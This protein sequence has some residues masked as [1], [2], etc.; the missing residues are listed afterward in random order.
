MYEDS[1]HVSVA[2]KP[3]LLVVDNERDL[4]L[5]IS[6]YLERGGFLFCGTHWSARRARRLR[7]ISS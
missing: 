4:C 7:G 2:L 3:L 6:Q 1:E 5:L